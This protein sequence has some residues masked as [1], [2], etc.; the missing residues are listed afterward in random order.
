M[1]A[2]QQILIVGG[3]IMGVTAALELR[4]R[5]HEVTLI[6]P[7]PLPHP[8]ASSTDISKMIRMDYGSDELYMDW[9]EEA[10][11]RWHEWNEL[12][13]EELYHEDGF[14][15]MT[16]E[17][18]RSGEFEYDSFRK[19]Q[20]RGHQP[21]RLD[22][23]ALA[24][25]FPA[26]NA[27]LYVDGYYNARA[28]WAESGRVLTR[29]IDAARA[30]GVRLREG[31]AMRE[32]LLDDARVRGVVLSDGAALRADAVIVAAGAWTPVLLPHLAEV[33][34][35]VGQ[36]VMHFRPAEPALFA[37]PN[38]TGFAADISNT[39]WYGFPLHQGVVK[40]ANH[41]EGQRLDPRG[42]K[43]VS[44]GEETRFRDFLRETFPALA[45]APCVKQR[46][47]LYCD[48]WDGHFWVDWDREYP[49]LLVATGGSGHA[50][51]FAPVLGELIADVLEGREN[52][53][54]ARFAWRE[55]GELGKED[56]RFW[57]G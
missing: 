35:V 48:T 37:L 8:E 54:A 18:M 38:F 15:I 28:G 57:E 47:C 7:G 6:D 41:G 26:W 4:R 53:F 42:P 20:Q 25:R 1:T 46:L 39:G 32:L 49:G 3:G 29:L 22:S 51:K 16:R 2:K 30:A 10:F 24:A 52:R 34:W 19:L 23:Q 11:P 21:E 55:R 56:A 44:A 40:I 45:D 27:A 5:S 43:K 50:F 31:M 17:E 36:P 33:M 12:W 14:V 9:M 13:G